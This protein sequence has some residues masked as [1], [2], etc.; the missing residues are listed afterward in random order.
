MTTIAGA[1]TTGRAARRNRPRR[2]PL[3][4]AFVAYLARILPTWRRARTA[5]MQTTAFTAIDVGLFGWHWIAG[6]IGI[7]VSLL[8][9]EALGGE[10]A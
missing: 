3:L 7:G 9:L 10:R 5:V 2:T 4:L 6:A 1:W 8:V